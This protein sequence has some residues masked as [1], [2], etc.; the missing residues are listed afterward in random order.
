ES[1]RELLAVD[2]GRWHDAIGEVREY[3]AEYGARMPPVLP[4]ECE[5]IASALSGMDSARQQ[6]VNG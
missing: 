3:L 6:V 2:P 1:V 4:R 5:R